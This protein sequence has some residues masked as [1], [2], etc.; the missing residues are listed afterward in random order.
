MAFE[1][2]KNS[3][4]LNFSIHRYNFMDQS[5]DEGSLIGGKLDVSYEITPKQDS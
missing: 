2:A 3:F 4:L 1:W 5:P